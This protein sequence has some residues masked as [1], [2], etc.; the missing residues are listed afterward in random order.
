LYKVRAKN[1][2]SQR[3]KSGGYRIIYYLKTETHCILV[4][5]YSKS[6]QGDITTEALNRLL[7]DIENNP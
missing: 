1:S 2:D 3:G 6:D 5:I 7:T 4:A